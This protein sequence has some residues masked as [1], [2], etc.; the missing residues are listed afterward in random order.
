MI[1]L[2]MSACVI[3]K[4]EEAHWR[5][6]RQFE[7]RTVNKR[8]LAVV[9]GEF[10]RDAGVNN[11]TKADDKYSCQFRKCRGGKTVENAFA[12]GCTVER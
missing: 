7:R 6:G 4:D 5:L 11:G 1:R 9:H 2:P 3:A 8:Y 12:G 10:D